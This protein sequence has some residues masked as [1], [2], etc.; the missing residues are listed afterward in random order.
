MSCDTA[1]VAII[2]TISI[3]YAL[4]CFK[5]IYR[6]HQYLLCF[7]LFSNLPD[8]QNLIQNTTPT[9]GGATVQAVGQVGDCENWELR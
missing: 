9:L 3:I 5:I 4:L 8:I 7:A 6:H 1:A 2:N